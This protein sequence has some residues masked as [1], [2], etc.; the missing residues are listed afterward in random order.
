MTV[1]IGEA[2]DVPAPAGLHIA[3]TT[4][5]TSFVPAYARLSGIPAEGVAATIEREKAFTGDGTV[6]RPLGIA[7]NAVCE[8]GGQRVV[9]EPEWVTGCGNH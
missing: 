1:A 2:A 3:E 8:R 9:S 4:D 5:L 7:Q 6:I